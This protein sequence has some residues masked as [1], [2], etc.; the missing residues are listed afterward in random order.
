MCVSVY[1]I[2]IKLW[3]VDKREFGWKVIPLSLFRRGMGSSE[4]NKRKEKEKMQSFNKDFF[5]TG[6]CAGT[7]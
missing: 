2:V 5:E 7:G 6:L 3:S 1:D 4:N